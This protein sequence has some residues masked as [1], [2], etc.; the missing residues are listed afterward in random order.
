MEISVAWLE[1]SA[2]IFIGRNL[3][4]IHPLALPGFPEK[5][6]KQRQRF[7]AERQIEPH[8]FAPPLPCREIA[9]DFDRVEELVVH[10]DHQAEQSLRCDRLIGVKRGAAAVLIEP[11]VEFIVLI[12][13]VGGDGRAPDLDAASASPLPLSNP[14]DSASPAPTLTIALL[15]AIESLLCARVAD[16]ISGLPRHDPNQELM[17]QGLA[18][19]VVPFFG[20]M[21]AT[22]TIARTVTNVRAGASSPVSGLV[23][24]LTLLVIVLVAAPLALHVPLAVLAGILMYV[25]WNMGE[26]RGLLHLRQYSSHYRLLMLGTFFMTVVFDLTVALQIGLVLACVLFVRRMSSLFQVTQ[27]ARDEGSASFQLCGSLFFGAVAKIDPVMTVVESTPHALLIRL[28]AQ[29]LQSL[30]QSGLAVLEQLHTA[31]TQRGGRLVITGLHTQP[32]QTMARAGFL[33]KIDSA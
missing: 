20:G 27:T 25:A 29:Q 3:G 7:L 30:D 22:G 26:W 6:L 17:A 31:V 11:H 19:L 24:A 33:A 4:L 12:D 13:P 2:R 15:G 28:D 21:P 14:R 8:S 5:T 32:L 23:H 16:Q 10:R 9:R 1:M 18:N